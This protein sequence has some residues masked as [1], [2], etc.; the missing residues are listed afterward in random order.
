[1]SDFIYESIISQR[2][3]DAKEVIIYGAGVLAKI[4][5]YCITSKPYNCSVEAFMVS[6]KE[7]NP[8]YLLNK[9]VVTVKDGCQNY[10]DDLVVVVALEKHLCDIEYVLKE[11]QYQNVILAGFESDLWSGIRG[12][13]FRCY[14]MDKNKDY[15]TLEECLEHGIVSCDGYLADNIHIYSAKCAVDKPIQCERK[16]PW[17]LQIQAGAALTDMVLSEIR[18]NTGDNISNKNKSYCELT[19]LYWIWKHDTAKYVGLDHYRRHFE[20][21]EE[22]LNKVCSSNI[23]V[24]LTIPIINYPSVRAIYEHDHLIEDWDTMLQVLKE[25]YLDYYH[26]ALDLQDGIYYYAYN[27]FIA[28]K[29]IFDEYC[30]WLFSILFE[31]EK[32]CKPREDKY[33]ARYLGFLAERLLSIFFIHNWNRWNIVHSKKNFLS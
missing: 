23:D 30:Q 12:N 9:P 5:A 26:T 16:Y 27:M 6:K 8:E 14:F 22:L 29:E 4:A 15:R 17:E 11:Y 10:K 21:S 2:I 7:N 24:I 1:M 18:D 31:C 19:A 3:C 20:L 28:R 32:R 25:V 33:Q 13:F